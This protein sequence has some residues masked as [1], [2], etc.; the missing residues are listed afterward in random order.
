MKKGHTINGFG[1][2]DEAQALEVADENISP[3][4]LPPECLSWDPPKDTVIT[5]F[6]NGDSER[7]I[8]C[9][10]KL[11][12]KE[13]EDLKVLFAAPSRTLAP[14]LLAMADAEEKKTPA[15]DDEDDDGTDLLYVPKS[16]LQSIKEALAKGGDALTKELVDKMVS[17]EDLGDDE[18]MVPIDAE[19]LGDFDNP[20]EMCEK[21][22]A[23]GAAE[24]FVKARE[25]MEAL[26]EA[27]QAPDMSAKEWQEQIK[28]QMEALAD[29]EGEGE[30]EEMGESEEEEEGDDDDE[31]PAKKAKSGE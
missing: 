11:D 2:T 9:N 21:L 6:K 29:M 26:P 23:K 12:E 10:I 19:K 13:L 16:V 30:E 3:H 27:E 28:E 15:A 5:P 31:P 20:E 24:A 22:G 4:S 14:P 7:K 25:A 17:M 8:H 1:F 18:V